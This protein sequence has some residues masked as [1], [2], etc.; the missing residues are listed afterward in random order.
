M[1]SFWVFLF[2]GREFSGRIPN[3]IMAV[4]DFNGRRI[5]SGVAVKPMVMDAFNTRKKSFCISMGRSPYPGLNRNVMCRSDCWA[6][7][8]NCDSTWSQ[9]TST[10]A[11]AHASRITAFVKFVRLYNLIRWSTWV[12]NV[13]A[14]RAHLC[15]C[16]RWF[17]ISC[18]CKMSVVFWTWI[19]SGRNSKLYTP[20][21]CFGREISCS[22]WRHS[23][24]NWSV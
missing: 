20:I 17:A 7:V 23:S 18:P 5:C 9:I 16:C 6:R 4:T 14:M 12:P 24:I 11:V 21:L 15:A 3:P 10:Y 13:T 2:V 1:A 8:L 19:P 22:S